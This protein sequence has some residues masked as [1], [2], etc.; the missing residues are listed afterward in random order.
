MWIGNGKCQG[1]NNGIISY[2]IS[3]YAG[4]IGSHVYYLSKDDYFII[5]I[6]TRSNPKESRSV[7]V[8]LTR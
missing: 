6:H 4:Q 8:H 5:E 7:G 1:L 3:T 2:D